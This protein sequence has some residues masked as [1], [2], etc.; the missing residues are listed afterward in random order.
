MIRSPFDNGSTNKPSFNMTAIIDIVFLLIIFFV[1]VS[2]FIEAENFEV[3]VPDHCDYAVAALPPNVPQTTVTAMRRED[4]VVYAVGSQIIDASPGR[5]L[6]RQICQQLDQRL[7]KLNPY[8]RIVTVRIDKQIQYADT[9][10]VLAAI[11]ESLADQ[12]QMATLN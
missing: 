3:D 8:E 10:W 9:Q 6:K 5:E 1:I 2:Q 11:A 4:R 12:I 7:A